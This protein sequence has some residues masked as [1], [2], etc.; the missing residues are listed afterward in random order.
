VIGVPDI[1]V[2]R[3][4]I[5]A[6]RLRVATQAKIRVVFDEEHAVN[7]PVRIMASGATFPQCLVLKNERARLRLVTLRAAFVLASHGQSARAL[8]HVA[9]MRIV[10]V[11][12]IHVALDDRVMLRQRKLRVRV[13]MA[14]KTGRRI[15]A[16]I[17]DEFGRTARANMFAAGTVAGF[18]TALPGH[19]GVDRMQPRMRAH[20]KFPDNIRVAIRAGFIAREMRAGNFQRRDHRL[21]GRARNQKA[22][23]TGSQSEKHQHRG[24]WPE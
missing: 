22:G 7:G 14:L 4:N 24:F 13:E 12:A 16:G 19:G 6:L 23:H 2:S 10:A 9:A 21:G 5:G 11:H 15:F 18:A 20:R 3:R 17:D 8:E 1:N